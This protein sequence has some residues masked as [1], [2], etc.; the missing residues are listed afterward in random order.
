MSPCLFNHL[1]PWNNKTDLKS[2]SFSEPPCTDDDSWPCLDLAEAG[3]CD[4]Y[5]E[6]CRKSCDP[7]C[8]NCKLNLKIID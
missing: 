1:F 2:T 4:E 6:Y 5:G 7:G 8:D 3:Y